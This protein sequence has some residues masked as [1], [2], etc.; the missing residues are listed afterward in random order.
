MDLLH[1][2]VK[3]KKYWEWDF[4]LIRDFSLIFS[5]IFP[6]L[7]YSDI[8]TVKSII[9]EGLTKKNF[10]IDSFETRN[11]NWRTWW[12]TNVFSLVLRNERLAN[13][14]GK[15]FLRDVIASSSFKHT[16]WAI[17]RVLKMRVILFFSLFLS[18]CQ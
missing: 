6:S 15:K 14:E 3:L 1:Q 16:S 12:K 10:S 4:W 17:S 7:T 13:K 18:A 9:F 8:E 11:F 2:T 5:S